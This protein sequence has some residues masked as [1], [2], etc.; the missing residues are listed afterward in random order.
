M[1]VLYVCGLTKLI[2]IMSEPT[3]ES[4]HLF[5]R[6]Y[7]LSNTIKNLLFSIHAGINLSSHDNVTCLTNNV[8]MAGAHKAEVITII[9]RK[10]ITQ[11]HKVSIT[12]TL[13][14][15]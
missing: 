1:K 6:I 14:S 15:T 5:T 4:G 3:K 10:K 9:S 7:A 13:A 8:G 12:K 11:A 2:L